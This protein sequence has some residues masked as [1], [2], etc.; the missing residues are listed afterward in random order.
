MEKEKL[1]SKIDEKIETENLETKGQKNR[2]EAIEIVKKRGNDAFHL[3]NY[4]EA[5]KQYENG[6]RFIGMLFKGDEKEIGEVFK[7]DLRLNLSLAHLKKKDTSESLMYC[8][9]VIKDDP[10]NIK[11]YYRKSQVF[12]KMG[13]FE[14]AKSEIDFI[15]NN[16]EKNFVPAKKLLKKIK[17]EELKFKKREKELFGSVLKKINGNLYDENEIERRKKEAS[18]EEIKRK[19]YFEGIQNNKNSIKNFDIKDEN[20]EKELEEL[21]EENF[22]NFEKLAKSWKFWLI[23]VVLFIF[24][25]SISLFFS[26]KIL[27]ILKNQ[28]K[29]KY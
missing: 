23:F 4:E 8:E 17:N 12:Y 2:I 19:E 6:L 15:L 3:K 1:N 18:E 16:L 27:K 26:F 13:Q 29:N 21:E 20:F 9:M 24:F 22:F 14:K 25:I 28:T 11:A 5:I 7:K 10:K